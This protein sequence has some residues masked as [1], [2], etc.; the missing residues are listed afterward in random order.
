MIRRPYSA[1][2]PG[3]L[4]L[5]SVFAIFTLLLLTT[6]VLNA[7]RVT[8]RKVDGQN[9][10]DAAA[11]AAGV[12]LARAMN[13]ITALNHLIGE[14]NALDAMVMAFGG[15]PLEDRKPIGI[16]N[17]ELESAYGSAKFWD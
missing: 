4:A 6:V 3:Q 16:R 13:A 11:H 14:L 8:T 10:A 1:R 5:V 7:G 15:L 9:A 12:E 17:A 2:R